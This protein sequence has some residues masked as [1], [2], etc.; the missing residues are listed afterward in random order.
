M[1]VQILAEEE[2]NENEDMVHKWKRS[3]TTQGTSLIN[4]DP[5]T[6]EEHAPFPPL[7]NTHIKEEGLVPS[8]Q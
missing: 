8:T 4:L 5:I 7:E 6:E 1:E 3:S 2:L